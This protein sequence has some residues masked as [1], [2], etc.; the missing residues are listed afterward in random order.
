MAALI[1]GPLS[2]KFKTVAALIPGPLRTEGKTMTKKRD[3]KKG[4]VEC[5]VIES[6]IIK[7]GEPHGEVGEIL[8]L[9]R[10]L[11][12]SLKGMG[13]V[14]EATADDKKARTKVLADRKKAAAEE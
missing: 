4:P 13:R 9:D 8:T 1:R 5:V 7:T 11:F 6:C 3:D 2:P 14:E 12:N 10:K